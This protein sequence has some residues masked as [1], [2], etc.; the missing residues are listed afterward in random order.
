MAI[1][2]RSAISLLVGI[3][4]FVGLPLV[5]WGVMDVRGF[6]GHPARLAYVVFAILL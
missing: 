4:I 6:P 2:L 3:A 1:A 5:G